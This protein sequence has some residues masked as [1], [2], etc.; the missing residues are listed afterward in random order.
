M[1]LF[2]NMYNCWN[3]FFYNLCFG[4]IFVYLYLLDE[5]LVYRNNGFMKFMDLLEL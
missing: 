4:D 2:G 3:I 1:Y 5:G